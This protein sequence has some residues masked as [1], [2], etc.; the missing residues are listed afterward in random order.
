M[1]NNMHNINI[2]NS[3]VTISENYKYLGL[4]INEFLDFSVTA[5]MLANSAGR[6]LGGM[7]NKLSFM[8]DVRFSTFTKLYDSCVKPIISYGSA[9]W[10]FRSIEKCTLIQRRAIRYFLGVHRFAPIHG[11]EGDMGWVPIK[12]CQNLEMLR[13]WNR[14][15]SLPNHRL[16]KKIFDWDFGLCNRNWSYE[17]QELLS[18]V[19]CMQTFMNREECDLELMQNMFLNNETVKW[20]AMRHTKD[21]LRT[22]NMFKWTYETEEYVSSNIRKNVR[23]LI[24]QFRLGILPLQIEIGRYRGIPLEERTCSFCNNVVEDEFHVLCKCPLYEEYRKELY[25][26]VTMQNPSFQNVDIIDKFIYICANFQE[27]LGMFLFKSM[28][29]RNRML[30]RYT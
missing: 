18:G 21:K 14:V 17:V 13:F 19:D 24:S 25:D 30:Y 11:I 28:Q 7:I 23:S 10:G 22:Y 9:I 8:K 3:V 16:T 20:D 15:V 27:Y 26:R 1:T 12:I 4:I 6:A 5:E 2:G 29:K